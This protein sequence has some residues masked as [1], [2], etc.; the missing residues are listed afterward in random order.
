MHARARTR[1][2]THK[3]RVHPR[4]RTAHT[5]RY[6]AGI[7]EDN[8]RPATD[9]LLSLWQSVA[10]WDQAASSANA[11]VGKFNFTWATADTYSVPE[12]QEWADNSA[13]AENADPD[14]RC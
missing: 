4:T 11:R 6:H 9:S 14:G 13:Y 7:V 3:P 12:Y 1:T 8:P 2:H 5:P 10:L